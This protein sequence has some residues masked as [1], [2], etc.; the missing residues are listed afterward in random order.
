MPEGLVGF[1]EIHAF[2]AE[3]K[4]PEFH[5]HVSDWQTI[6]ALPLCGGV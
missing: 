2:T 4:N 1:K 6:R 5:F 3:M